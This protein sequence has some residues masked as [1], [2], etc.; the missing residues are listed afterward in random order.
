MAHCIMG[1]IFVYGRGSRRIPSQQGEDAHPGISSAICRTCYSDKQNSTLGGMGPFSA[2]GSRGSPHGPHVRETPA[3]LVR[4]SHRMP[5][6]ET[7]S[8]TCGP[9]GCKEAVRAEIAPARRKASRE[10]NIVR[11]V[12]RACLGLAKSVLR[13]APRLMRYARKE[14][15]RCTDLLNVRE[16]SAD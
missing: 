6:K 15:P 1:A 8:K 11:A 9:I 13:P 4:S 16:Y 7:H 2:G 14:P 3:P 5:A 10:G 12:P